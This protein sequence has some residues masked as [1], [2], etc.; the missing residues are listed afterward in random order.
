[1]VSHL[2]GV[3]RPVGVLGRQLTPLPTGPGAIVAGHLRRIGNAAGSHPLVR[4]I[5]RV[6]AARD[7]GVGG[8]AF[9]AEV[10]GLGDS[11]SRACFGRVGRHDCSWYRSKWRILELCIIEPGRLD[12]VEGQKPEANTSEVSRTMS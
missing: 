2:S 1:M 5:C 7:N 12:F 4:L 3:G 6:I 11:A 8:R 9:D 10:D